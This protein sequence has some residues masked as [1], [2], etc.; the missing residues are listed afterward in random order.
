M[1]LAKV[2]FGTW[3]ILWDKCIESVNK[4]IKAW[5]KHID[6]AQ[7]YQNET[8]VWN[9]IMQSEIKREDIQITSK[10]WKDNMSSENTILNSLEDSLRKL[11]TNYLDLFLVH[12]PLDNETNLKTI[13]TLINCKKNWL[14]RSIWV[15]N[16]TIQ[17]LE[18]ID[19]NIW[20]DQIDFNQI[21]YHLFFEP[22]NII[23]YCNS[24][25]IKIIAYSPLSHWKILKDPQI[26][27]IG[28]K[29]NKT[30]GQIALKWLIDKNIH[31]IP[32]SVNHMEENIN[33]FDFELDNEDKK[34]LNNL[35]KDRRIIKPPFVP[36][37][38]D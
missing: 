14:I 20:L 32:K 33:I 26:K 2:W 7:I 27:M 37:R 22:K 11:K 17:N 4:A 12:W 10:L 3:E 9:W 24:K 34:R 29:H 1:K 6:T 31:I 23:N 28:D 38:D 8:E 30:R 36:K 21:E 13:K 5:Y 19:K 16:F 25:W 35:P 18:Y 15:S